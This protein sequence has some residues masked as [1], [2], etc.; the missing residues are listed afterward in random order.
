MRNKDKGAGCHSERKRN[1][2]KMSLGAKVKGQYWVP[3]VW[4]AIEVQAP[5]V[6]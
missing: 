4:T 6:P 3:S 1:K 2:C 5:L